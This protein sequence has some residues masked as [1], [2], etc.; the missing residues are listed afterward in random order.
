[1]YIEEAASTFPKSEADLFSVKPMQNNIESSQIV[2][3][4][5]ISTGLDDCIEFV[6]PEGPEYIDLSLTKIHLKVKILDNLGN[7]VKNEWIPADAAEKTPK[8]RKGIHIAPGNN[9]LGSLFNQVLLFFNHKCIT[10]PGSNHAYRS[11]IE[12]LLNYDSSSKQTHLQ[13]SLFIEDSTGQMDVFDNRGA[14]RRMARMGTN[15]NIELIG[16]L[17]TDLSNM[18]KLLLNNVNLRIKLY[19]NKPSFSLFANAV[20]NPEYKIN[21]TEATL[22]VRKVR[23]DPNM[24]KL[25]EIWLRSNNA[26]YC[27]ERN[28]I[29]SFTIPAGTVNHVLDNCFISQMPKRVF[30]FAIAEEDEFNYRRSPYKFQHFDLKRVLLSGDNYSNLRPVRMN[31][32]EM[33]YIEAFDNFHDALNTYFQDTSVAITPEQFMSGAFILGWDLTADLSA[34]QDYVSMPK[35]GTL[36]LELEYAKALPSNIK[37]MLYAEYNSFI[38]IDSARNVYTDYAC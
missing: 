2:E 8:S 23:M 11:Y 9:F 29:K 26:K 4:R 15:G 37:L 14:V 33:E 17:H 24:I 38:S 3:Y 20:V 18:N 27:I 5:P 16:Y 22:L 31:I 6:I 1:M 7:P 25:N 19:R 30:M 36:R 34:S 28:E 13:S 32:A 10:S 35:S 21:I 12:K